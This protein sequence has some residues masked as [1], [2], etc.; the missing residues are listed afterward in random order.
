MKKVRVFL[1]ASVLMLTVGGVFAFKAHAKFGTG[2]LYEKEDGE[3]ILDTSCKETTSGGLL[4]SATHYIN[5]TCT[6][7]AT[8][9][10]IVTN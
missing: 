7:E 8:N 9:D 2:N 4:C 6:T 10:E 3:C 1:A 5:S